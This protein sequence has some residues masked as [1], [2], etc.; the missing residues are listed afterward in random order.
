[1]NR[2]L[3]AAFSLLMGKAALLAAIVVVREIGG[4]FRRGHR[5][6]SRTD[7]LPTIKSESGCLRGAKC[8]S[9]ERGARK[10]A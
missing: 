2:F 3:D 5:I 4:F 7:D 9:M 8:H 1:M 6:G 10:L